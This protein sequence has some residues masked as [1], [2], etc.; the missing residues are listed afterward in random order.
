MQLTA[1]QLADY[2]GVQARTVTNWVNSEPPCPST[3]DGRNRWFDSV[4]VAA[5]KEARL[6]AELVRESAPL[7]FEDAKKRK[8][9]A[10]AE[11]MELELAKLRGELV[12]I[13]E[14]RLVMREIAARIRS[15]L[16][17]VPGRYSA[18]MVGLKSLPDAARELDHAVRDV[19]NELKEG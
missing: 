1:K 9:A 3:V 2:Y 17:A 16:L 15:Q 13:E 10:E 4:A 6:R 8:M 18:R 12:P 7:D 5:W 14:S 19:L 11:L